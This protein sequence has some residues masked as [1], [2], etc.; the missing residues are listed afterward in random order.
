MF[1]QTRTLK[2]PPRCKAPVPHESAPAKAPLSLPRATQGGLMDG[3]LVETDRGWRPIE[4]LRPG[5]GIMSY[6]GGLCKLQEIRPVTIAAAACAERGMLH[7]PAGVLDNCS[8]LNLHDNQW[9]MIDHPAVYAYLD[10]STVLIPA[11]ALEGFR[12]IARN[13]ECRRRRVFVLTFADEEIIYG[14]SGVL[15]HC[16]GSEGRESGFFTRIGTTRARA[17]LRLL[18]EEQTGG[19]QPWMM[20]GGV[21]AA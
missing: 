17:L 4:S 16:P 9:I 1:S 11:R 21:M 12:G 15:F 3:T 19:M 6:D 14:N 5:A 10:I 8:E 20:A 2:E 13:H 18:D 7:V